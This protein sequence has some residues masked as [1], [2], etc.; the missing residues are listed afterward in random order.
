VTP[1]RLAALGLFLGAVPLCAQ[2]APDSAPVPVIRGVVVEPHDIFEPDEAQA[3]SL[4]RFA[5]SIHATTRRSVVE[6]ELLFKPGDLFDSAKVAETARNLRAMGIFRR[7]I[8][9]SIH[10]DSGTIL[11]VTTKD[12]WSTRP[13]F[14]FNSTAGQTA[15]AVG[16]EELNLFGRATYASITYSDTP[17]RTAITLQFRQPRL[18]ANRIYAAAGYQ[19]R[20]DGRSVSAGM[21]LPFLSLASRASLTTSV[22]DFDGDVLR[23]LEGDPV[24]NEVLRRRYTVGRVDG[25]L[26]LSGSSAGFVRLGLFGQ[27]RRDDFLDTSLVT[28]TPFPHTIT[29]AIGPYFWASRA[30]FLVLRNFRSF[31]REE[32][33]D[34]SSTFLIGTYAAPKA[35]G[36]DH[37]GVGLQGNAGTGVRLP[38]GFATLR[39]AATGL[40]SGSGLDSGTVRVTGTWVVQPSRAHSLVVLGQLGWQDNPTPGE[41]FDLGLSRGPRAFYAHAFTGDRM[42]NFLVEYRWTMAESWWDVL[43]LGLAGFVDY[44]GAWYSGSPRRTGTDA[45]FGLRLGPS[46]STDADA[47]VSIDFARRFETDIQ[48]AG[49]AVVVRRGVRF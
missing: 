17:D 33:V 19:H 40:V 16:L 41:E 29:A 39:A 24:P 45:G 46:R 26:A 32:D 15:W 10:T 42:V 38:G 7:V 25:A 21:G 12:G 47:V 2:T 23:F 6:R 11:R 44:G 4:I 18:I 49:W 37:D 30:S 27:L 8:I 35:F 28:S 14:D 20:S 13:Q 34:L 48:R 1:F 36:Y 22:L 5:N 31:A 43:G 3:S 9:D